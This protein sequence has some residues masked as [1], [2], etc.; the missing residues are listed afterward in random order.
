M[1][2]F[3]KT[4]TRKKGFTLIGVVLLILSIGIIA[5]MAGAVGVKLQQ[6]AKER[7]TI[8]RMNVIKKALKDYYRAHQDLPDPGNEVTTL[9][10]TG[11]KQFIAHVGEIPVDDLNLE[12]KQ[13]T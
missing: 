5:F 6:I 3:K 12:Q 7:D 1:E 8:K 11:G 2:E 4:L 13:K 10:S 9:Y